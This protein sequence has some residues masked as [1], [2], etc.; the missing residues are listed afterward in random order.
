MRMLLD[1]TGLTIDEAVERR[2]LAWAPAMRADSARYGR[3]GRGKAGL[4]LFIN[5]TPLPR[6]RGSISRSFIFMSNHFRRTAVAPAIENFA[7]LFEE[8]LTRKEMRI[9]EVITA[10]VVRVDH[11]FVVVN[12]GLKSERSFPIEEFRN[13][14]GEVEVKPGDFV[15][16]RHRS[17]RRRLRRDAPVARQGQAPRGVDRPREGARDGRRSCRASSPAR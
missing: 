5:P 11:N 13:D 10:E 4:A 6:C 12:A 1:T 14:R 9:G 15:S 2:W 7:A 3:S 17:A 8:S 16:G